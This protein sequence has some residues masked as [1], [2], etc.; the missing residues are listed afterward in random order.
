MR[1]RGAT[2]ADIAILVVAGNDGV[3]KQTIEAIQI[4]K[5]RN[6]PCLVA[7]TK[8]DLQGINVEK[9][10]QQ[11]AE[12]EVFVEG[13]GGDT[14]V[15]SLSS[16]TGA[17]VSELLDM[18]LLISQ[19]AGLKGNPEETATGFIIESHHDS[20]RGISATLVIKNGALEKG[21]YAVSSGSFSPVRR[22][23]NFLGK[24][25]EMALFSSPIRIMG[26]NNIPHIG[27]TFKIVSSKKEAEEE[28]RRTSLENKKM[29][30]KKPQEQTYEKESGAGEKITTI[31]LIIKADMLGTLEAISN[32]IE[33]MRPERVQFNILEKSVG[34]IS[35]SDIKRA[36]SNAKGNC[37]AI[38]VGFN[39]AIEERARTLADRLGIV[40]KTFDIIYRLTEWL[41]K[42]ANAR[43]PKIQVN[44]LVGRA[45]IVRVFSS[46]KNKHVVGGKVLEGKL[47][48]GKIFKLLRREHEIDAGKI[49]ELQHKKE[50]AKDVESGLEFGALVETK[51]DPAAGDIIE[52]FVVVEK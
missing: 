9:V 38:I 20:Q 36:A 25:L 16:K 32:D 47:A 27:A 40:L 7:I 46:S 49:L 42:E 29:G 14:P 48:T 10:K 19:V 31:P 35:E 18:V 51:H 43:K 3:K 37:G 33:K 13:Y 6:I 11:L 52:I 23:E 41:A 17:G 45:R 50:K 22:I 5:K 21:S 24:P 39:I 28:A 12:N 1:E 26:W 15:I 34:A 30:S 44:E 2:I 8:A 4:I